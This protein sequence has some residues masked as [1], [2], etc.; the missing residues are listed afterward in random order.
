MLFCIFILFCFPNVYFCCCF[1]SLSVNFYLF[2]QVSVYGS[3]WIKLDWLAW[4]FVISLVLSIYSFYCLLYP[5]AGNAGRL[6]FVR[7]QQP[8]EQCYPFLPVH[9]VFSCFRTMVWLPVL[10]IFIVRTD[11]SACDCT[12]VL[13]GDL[14]RLCAERKAEIACREHRTRDRKGA[15]LNPG[16]SGGR[17]FF[18]RLNLV[19]WL[20]FGIRSTPVLPRWHLQDSGHFAKSAGGRLH[21]NTPAPLTR[22]SRSGLSMP[23]SRH[24][25]GTNKE[26]SSHATR[27]GILSHSRLSSLS[28][29]GL[30]LAYRMELVFAS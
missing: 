20:L 18:C 4:I 16:R 21:L 27:Q 14:K 25:V 28:H 29:C 10:G 22:R 5:F 30:I 9:A 26:T 13:Y 15:S 7:L 19:Y 24:S 2:V 1:V 17:I 12:W 8:Q 6:T 23:L 3:V 11:V